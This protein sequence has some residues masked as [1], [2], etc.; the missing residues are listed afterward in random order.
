MATIDLKESRHPEGSEKAAK[1]KNKPHNNATRD[2]F[3][4]PWGLLG[5]HFSGVDESLS[6][7]EKLEQLPTVV[8]GGAKRDHRGGVKRDHLA[9]AGLSP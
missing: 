1:A 2:Q 3:S 8:N 6:S 4:K 9:A 5:K 7:D